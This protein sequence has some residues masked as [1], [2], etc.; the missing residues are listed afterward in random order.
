MGAHGSKRSC[1]GAIPRSIRPSCPCPATR[2]TRRPSTGNALVPSAPER[3]RPPCS[4]NTVLSFPGRTV[5][6]GEVRRMDIGRD[7]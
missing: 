3:L 7:N 6:N 2:S 4:V 5:D 1:A